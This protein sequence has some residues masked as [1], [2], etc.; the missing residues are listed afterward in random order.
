M[1]GIFQYVDENDN[2]VYERIANYMISFRCY[3]P[4]A[5]KIMKKLHQHFDD[6]PSF[7]DLISA[8]TG[9]ELA[10]VSDIISLPQELVKDFIESASFTIEWYGIDSIVDVNTTTIDTINIDK[11][12][13]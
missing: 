4:E 7:R 12:F 11:T 8:E 1:N 2:T 13:N 10:Q 9:G 3:G 6:L 5:G